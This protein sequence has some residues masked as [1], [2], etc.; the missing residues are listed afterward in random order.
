MLK[1]ILS[2]LALAVPQLILLSFIV[3]TLT[4]FVPGSVAAAILGAAATPQGVAALETQ[5]GLDRPFFERLAE[6]YIGVFQGD[7]GTSYMT[8]RPVADM[9]LERLPATL[10]L[11]VGGLLFAIVIGLA[12]GLMGGTKPG[13]IRDRLATA[14]SSLT[15]SVPEFWLGI[16][17]VLIFSVQLR[18]LPVV[19]YVPFATDPAGALRGLLLPAFALGVGG[20]ALIARQTRQAMASTM[21]SKYIDSLTAAG[22]ERQRLIFKYGLKN[23]MVP[24]LSSVGITVS[25][26]LGASFSI[27][28]VFSF[29]GI[30]TLLLRS[31]TSKDFAVLQGG[32]LMIAIM[33]ILLNIVLDVSYGL[34]NPKSRPQ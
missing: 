27:E 29:P 16:V 34:I 24:V 3:F 32:V 11:M 9:F 6:W 18:I 25:I 14:T 15:M 33:I 12:L 22:V 4:Y 1:L 17:L 13:S 30:G 31:V 2:R 8:N 7:F 21:A 5:L 23:S 20:A 10:S 19:S 26:M 28:K